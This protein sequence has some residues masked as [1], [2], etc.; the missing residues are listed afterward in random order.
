MRKV[1]FSIATI[2]LTLFSIPI[3]SQQVFAGEINTVNSKIVGEVTKGLSSIEVKD[4]NLGDMT[5]GKPINQVKIEKGI[6]VTDHSGGHGWQATV[7]DPAH[8]ENRKTIELSVNG[9]NIS[10]SA[11]NITNGETKLSPTEVDMTID[12]L[13]GEYPVLGDYSSTLTWT[14]TPNLPEA[15]MKWGTAGV[16]I[17]PSGVAYVSNGEIGSSND[18]GEYREKITKVVIKEN[19]SFPKK[20][21]DTFDSMKNLRSIENLSSIDASNTEHMDYTFGRINHLESLDLTGLDLRKVNTISGWLLNTKVDNLN[22]STLDLPELR[23]DYGLFKGL[24]TGVLDIS[25]LKT[26]K[27]KM[28]HSTFDSLVADEVIIGNWE[29]STGYS[30]RSTFKGVNFDKTKIDVSHWRLK[31]ANDF[32]GIFSNSVNPSKSGFEKWEPA[33]L[34]SVAEVFKYAK[35][36][37]KVIDLSKW[38]FSQT[39]EASGMFY[40]TDFD[41]VAMGVEDFNFTD[42]LTRADYM[43][44]NSKYSGSMNLNKWNMSNAENINGMFSYSKFNKLEVDEWRLPPFTPSWDADTKE[45]YLSNIFYNSPA[46]VDTSNWWTN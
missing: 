32:N 35:E 41:F 8:N 20:A 15:Q 10:D 14:L 24:S 17:F 6:K 46:T 37:N 40:G 22:V 16:D 1:S 11:V 34:L 12:S 13:W 26:P 39:Y 30:F 3:L 36:D 28:V 38:D 23:N 7:S 43:F 19:V 2:G 31:N 42:K 4:V 18:L 45:K 27:V 21:S 5:I 44:S 29:P 25:E 33:P 9:K